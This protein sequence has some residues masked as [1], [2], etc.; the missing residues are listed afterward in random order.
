MAAGYI[1]GIQGATIRA[2]I[3]NSMFIPLHSMILL[4]PSLPLIHDRMESLQEG[5]ADIYMNDVGRRVAAHVLR[6]QVELLHKLM[7][8]GTPVRV[9]SSLSYNQQSLRSTLQEMI[10]SCVR[11]FIVTSGE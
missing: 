1:S 7:K 11:D 5:L 2:L 8:K 3:D 4:N 10:P 9:L 6:L